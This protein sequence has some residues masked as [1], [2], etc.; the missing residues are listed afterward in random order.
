MVSNKQDG[1]EQT[2]PT[3]ESGIGDVAPRIEVNVEM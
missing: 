2:N 1:T 3:K